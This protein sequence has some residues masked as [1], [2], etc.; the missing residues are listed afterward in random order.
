MKS[1]FFVLAFWL[2]FLTLHAQQTDTLIRK[3]DSLS[4]K[5]D[6]ADRQIN[7]TTPDAY[8]EGTRLNVKSYFVLLGS[9][10]KQGFTKPFHMEGRGWGLLA[11]YA[12]ATAVLSLAGKPVQGEGGNCATRATACAG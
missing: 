11:G 9:G 7:N 5:T 8:N 3:L 1:A 10:I 12:G 6:S 2:G 4:R